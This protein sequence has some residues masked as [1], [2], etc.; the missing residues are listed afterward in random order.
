VALVW[1]EAHRSRSGA[2]KR[3][4]QIKS[5]NRAKKQELV[6]GREPRDFE[7]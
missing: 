6:E 5:W 2:A 1:Y 3:E 7:S 4:K